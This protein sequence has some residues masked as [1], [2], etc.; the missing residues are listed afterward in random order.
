MR[1]AVVDPTKPPPTTV[2]FFR[3]NFSPLSLRM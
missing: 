1:C 3:M 2:T